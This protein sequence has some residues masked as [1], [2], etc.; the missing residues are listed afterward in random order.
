MLD[1]IA[2]S[3]IILTGGY[4]TLDHA[5]IVDILRNSL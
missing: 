4:Q 2:D 1:R 5:E 3:T